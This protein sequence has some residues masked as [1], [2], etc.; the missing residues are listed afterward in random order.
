MRDRELYCFV[1]MPFTPELNY[2]YLYFS[3]HIRRVHGLRCERAD[4]FV[5]TVPVLDKIDTMIRSA[6][7]LVADCSGRNPNVFYELGMAH[8]L[9]KKVILITSDEIAQAPS[10]IRHYEFIKYGLSDHVRFLDQLDNALR[11]VLGERYEQLF[12][13]ACHAFKEFQTSLPLNVARASRE[14]FIQRVINAEA[15]TSVPRVTDRIQFTEFVLPKIV[16]DVSDAVVMRRI[17]TY[18][19]T[20]GSQESELKS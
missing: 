1:I 11:N 8:A 17:T 5:L 15:F 18:L 12:I 4:A 10:D 20:I 7:A 3:D 9:E 13:D 14:T 16:A 2:F 19:S 6:D